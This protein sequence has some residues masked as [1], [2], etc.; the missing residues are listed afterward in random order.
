[1]IFAAEMVRLIAAGKKTATRRLVKGDEP[2]GRYRAGKSYAVQPGRGKPSSFRILVTDV[3]QEPVGDLTLADARAEGFRTSDEFKLYWIRLHDKAW[4]NP[5]VDCPECMGIGC[6]DCDDTGKVVKP[7]DDVELLARFE[8]RH[9]H[10]LV[11]V[12]MFEV[13]RTDRPRYL[14]AGGGWNPANA[15]RDQQLREAGHAIPTREEDSGYTRN[16]ALALPGEPEAVSEA[17]QAWITERAGMTTGQWL[18]R[19]ASNHELERRLL[20][21]EERI[22]RARLHAHA[23]RVDVTREV[24]MAEK[25]LAQGRSSQTVTRRIEILERKAYTT[26]LDRAAKEAA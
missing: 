15:K 5:K 9:A 16:A 19:H 14:A 17:D 10:R 22:R 11:W 8:D 2:K 26:P 7:R 6:W 1:M 25:L 20:A 12:I 18:A 24:W 3:R 4:A 23:N 21:H 13:D